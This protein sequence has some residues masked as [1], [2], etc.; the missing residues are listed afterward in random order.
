MNMEVD[1][2]KLRVETLEDG[3]VK[4]KL[5]KKSDFETL[6]DVASDPEVWLE[7]P[8][9]DRYKREVFQIYFDQ[10]LSASAAFLIIDKTTD[11]VVGCTMFHDYNSIDSS[12]AIGFTFLSRQYWG[13]GFNRYSKKIMLEFAFKLVNKVFFYI[14][15][16]NI[17][18]QFA[19]KKLGAIL[20]GKVDYTHGERKIETLRYVIWKGFWEI[21]SSL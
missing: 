16:N 2:Q 9:K 21:T 3:I 13:S 10:A 4:L 11:K 8:I 7:H 17:R 20:D 1:V 6:F 5:L 15:E 12:V 19:V 18:P 14:G